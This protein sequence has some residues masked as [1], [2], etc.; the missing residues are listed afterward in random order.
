MGLRTR[1]ADRRQGARATKTGGAESGVAQG[2]GRLQ[3]ERS[4]DLRHPRQYKHG[5]DRA[6]QHPTGVSE[7]SPQCRQS[8]GI[9]AIPHWHWQDR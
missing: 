8:G 1:V 4:D 9:E 3:Q 5:Q 2:A 6:G 7:S